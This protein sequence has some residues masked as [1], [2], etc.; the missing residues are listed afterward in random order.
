[1]T[2]DLPPATPRAP[3]LSVRTRITVTVAVL[4]GFAL[5]GSG[6]VVYVL[7]SARL[8]TEEQKQ[9]EQGITEFADL[10]DPAIGTTETFPNSRALLKTFL[11]RNV[12]NDNELIVGWW[13]GAAQQFQGNRRREP[14]LTS[15]EFTDAV[16][17]RL[18]RGGSME[19]P[20]TWGDALVTV[21]PVRDSDD[22]NA[23]VL[24]SFLEEGRSELRR[25]M[26]TYAAVAA[27]SLGLLVV[28][29][30]WQAGRLLRPLRTLQAAA[31]EI[32]ETDL[33]LRIQERGNDDITA[34]TRTFNEML[35][36]LETAFEEQRRFLDA[37]GHE[38]KTPLTVLRGHLELLDSGN[39]TE[40]ADTRW[41]LL[42]ET[43]RMGRLVNDLIMLAKAD[44]PD[45]VAPSPVDVSLLV[46][47]VLEKCRALG[48]RQWRVDELPEAVVAVDGQRVTQAL[49]Q[50][51]ANAVKHTW[52]GS[53]IALGA[54]VDETDVTLWVRDEGSGV[55]DAD[56]E[57]IFERFRR[58]LV[59]PGDEG[60]GL[61]LSVVR[62]IA[63][64]HG[65]TAHVEDAS[66]AGARFVMTLP[67][68]EGA[69]AWHG[70]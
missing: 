16:T 13:N 48:D 29:A 22:Y 69:T 24:V 15:A 61:G 56:K 55:P 32:T 11:A 30:A 12:P 51:A 21:Q 67:V 49:L 62:A 20:T 31:H 28:L 47:T 40:V 18:P 54:R 50:L 63:Q 57:A 5:L 45:F 9:V 7:T 34:L 41:L 36:R 2:P 38:L 3:A 35:A 68:T 58:S 6:L 4:V 19:I 66:P 25:T 52:P 42:D 70:S 60:F 17:A 27:L 33:S 26:Q 23:L 14:M 46:E 44:R 43:D 65:G 59:A 64:A 37:A 1:M 39:P 8:D 53:V 10:A